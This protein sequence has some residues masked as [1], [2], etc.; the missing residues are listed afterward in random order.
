MAAEI[1]LDR[2]EGVQRSGSGWRARCPSCNGRSRKVSVSEADNGAVLVHCFGGCAAGDVLQ[3]V[4]LSL[5][6]MFPE[7]LAADTPEDRRTRRQAAVES[8]W[9]AALEVLEFEARIIHLAGQQL[10]AGQPLSAED[11]AR[12][13]LAVRRVE[14]ARAILRPYRVTWRP[15][16]VAS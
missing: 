7:R 10:A 14:E 2:L 15:Q 11:D 9:G 12:L 3:A 5:A 16:Q 6:D 13:R 1:L 8:Q 4:G